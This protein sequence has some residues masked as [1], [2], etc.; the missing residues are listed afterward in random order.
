MNDGMDAARDLDRRLKRLVKA[1]R[2]AEA[3]VARALLDMKRRGLFRVL[4]YSRIQDYAAVELDMGRDKAKEL[5]D[6]AEK[7]EGLP[8]IS[9]EFSNGEITWTKARLIARVAKVD[10]EEDWIAAARSLPSRVLERKVATAKGERPKVRVVLE[11]TEEEAADLDQAVR[12]LREERGDVTS[13]S[14][15]V[16][17]FSRRAMGPPVER[18]GYQVVI[19]ECPTCESASRDAVEVAPEDLAAAKVDAEILDLRH[20]G[21]GV[22]K[23]TIKPSERRAVIARD[24]GQCVLCGT[25]AWLHI[26]HVVRRDGDV[27]VLSLLCSSCHKQVVHA[28]YVDVRLRGGRPEFHLRDGSRAPVPGAA[29]I[30]TQDTP[31]A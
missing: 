20:G 6:L 4:G 8:Q 31:C 19:H 16:A 23:K 28:R 10:D 27:A 21:N 12:M 3:E 26:H 29:T 30:C 22:L 13:V 2:S 25:K 7:L 1:A 11:L 5:A 14:A 24:R 15:A 18:P 9:S 17:E